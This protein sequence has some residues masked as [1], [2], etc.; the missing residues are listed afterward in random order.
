MSLPACSGREVNDFLQ[1]YAEN[2]PNAFHDDIA[3]VV[4]YLRNNCW[5]NRKGSGGGSAKLSVGGVLGVTK[6]SKVHN[7]IKR[8]KGGRQQAQEVERQEVT[9]G[10]R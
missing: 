5:R 1:N 2:V 8:R 6:Y 4:L 3:A 10:H 9:A 7:A